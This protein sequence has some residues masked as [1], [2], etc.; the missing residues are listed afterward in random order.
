MGDLNSHGPVKTEVLFA[1]RHLSGETCWKPLAAIDLRLHQSSR[2][3]VILLGEPQGSKLQQA[4]DK[5]QVGQSVPGC[6]ILTKL[7][8]LK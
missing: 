5:C 6:V 4:K 3:A 8:L 1:F 7:I 2:L